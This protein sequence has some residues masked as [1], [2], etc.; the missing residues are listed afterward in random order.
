MKLCSNC[1][2]EKPK[3]KG[4]CGACSSYFRLNGEERPERLYAPEE[5]ATHCINCGREAEKIIKDRCNRCYQYFIKTGK[6]RSERYW[7]KDAIRDAKKRAK[8]ALPHPP[9]LQLAPHQY[10]VP[11]RGNLHPIVESLGEGRHF[12]LLR[13]EYGNPVASKRSDLKPGEVSL[14]LR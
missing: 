14:I 6:D 10:I 5:P 3:I 4:R 2:R 9:G 1:N 13:D 11:G 8:E 7:K 12:A